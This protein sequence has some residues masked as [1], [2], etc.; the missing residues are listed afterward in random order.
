MKTKI[1]IPG[2]V[3]GLLV[4]VAGV[5]LATDGVEWPREVLSGGATGSGASGLDLQATLGQPVVGLVS[6]SSGDVILGQGF[7]RGGSLSTAWYQVYL[8][9]AIR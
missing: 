7:W 6:S 1:L 9:L 8:P 5:A 4:T 2:L 3:L